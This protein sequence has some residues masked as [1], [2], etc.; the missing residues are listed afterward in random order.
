[1][2]EH[3]CWPKPAPRKG[4]RQTRPRRAAACGLWYLWAMG[5]NQTG[6]DTPRCLTLAKLSSTFP[7]FH[8][9]QIV[10]GCLLPPP[11]HAH[12]CCLPR[13]AGRRNPRWKAKQTKRPPHKEKA[14]LST[15]RL[16]AL[17]SDAAADRER[18]THGA[19]IPCFSQGQ[20]GER[21]G[22]M[23]GFDGIHSTYEK[24]L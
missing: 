16:W 7:T 14:S 12:C 15:P 24:R 13:S 9:S 10:D 22:K 1:M 19:L 2:Q 11:A 18:R 23:F 4:L 21:R 17:G 5:R 6:N 20:A 8:P 3:C